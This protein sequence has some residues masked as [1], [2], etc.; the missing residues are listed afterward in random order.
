MLRRAMMRTDKKFPKYHQRLTS[1][2]R[3]FHGTRFEDDPHFDMNN[4]LLMSRLPEP[5]GKRELDDSMGRFIAQD[6]NLTRPLW[7]MVILENYH[8]EDG[9]ECAMVSR[10]HHTLADGQGFVL[11]QLYMTSYYEELTKAMNNGAR[12]LH[13]ARRGTLLPSKVHPILRPLDPYTDPLNV[14]IAPLVQIFLASLF[15]L[16]YAFSLP[17]SFFFSVYQALLQITMFILTCRRVEMLTAPQYGRRVHEREFSSSKVVDMNDI[18]L[19]QQAFSGLYPGSVVEKEKGRRDKVRHVTLNDVMCSVMADVL[20]EEVIS[21]PQDTSISGRVRKMLAKYLP[22]PI[23]FF[24]PISIRNPG[25]WSL[26][27]LSTGSMVYLY[28]MSPDTSIG[29][30]TLYDH[31]HRCR[32]ALSLLKHSLFPRILFYIMQVTGQVPTLWPVPF[33][34]LDSSKNLVRK[35]VLVPLIEW[36]LRSFPVVLTNVPGPAKNTITLEGIE[37]MC[38]MAL[39]SQSGTGTIGVGIISYAGGLCISV[40]ADKVPASEGVTRRICE[41]FERRFDCYVR[42]AKEVIEHRD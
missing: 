21:K 4:H 16:T 1:V 38:W 39:P 13:A 6:W 5:A 24:I 33:G 22:S 37:V 42:C 7:E 3:K 12:T 29:P 25:D 34:L 20:A 30:G 35:W 23:G 2:G 11:S 15:W 41:R 32:S 9:G 36:S 40:A 28:P 18:R 26:R 8:D 10:G 27:N 31:I 14:L 19:C 17:V